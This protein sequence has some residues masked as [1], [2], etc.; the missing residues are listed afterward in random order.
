MSDLYQE[1]ERDHFQKE[2]P[3]RAFTAW[4]VEGNYALGKG[5]RPSLHHLV[6][7]LNALDE[8]EGW[9][10]VQVLE[11]TSG[12]PSFLFRKTLRS[13]ISHSIGKLN[14][15]DLAAN[16]VAPDDPG[17]AINQA[18]K[19]GK[20]PELGMGYGLDKEVT[21]AV[22]N[23]YLADADPVNPKHYDG[24]ACADIGERLSA[25]G[26]QILKYVWRLGKKDDPCVELGK[27][28][29]YLGSEEAYMRQRPD[30]MF[31]RAD[32]YG[33]TDGFLEDRLSDQPQFTQNIARMLWEGYDLRRLQ[34]IREALDEHR[35]HLDCGRGLAV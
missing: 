3:I 16:I 33:L 4:S 7:Y 9:A 17:L 24:R 27:A 30:W 29:W 21:E 13:T 26:Y 15:E 18:R 20:M 14:L 5:F 8:K 19:L 2:S 22:F 1:P 35:F 25:N 23:A 31:A 34:A 11:A 10:V 6:T 12:T 32:I 28:L